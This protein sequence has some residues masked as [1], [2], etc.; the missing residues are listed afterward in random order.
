MRVLTVRQPWAHAIIHFGKDVENRVRN[1]AGGYRGLV[2]IH[3]AKAVDDDAPKWLWGDFHDS[4]Q[5][6]FGSI[7][8]V[9]DLVDVHVVSLTHYDGM[10]VCFDDKTPVGGTC[11]SW[12]HAY[13]EFPAY[14]G[15]HL[16]LSNP[17]PLVEP[18]PFKGALGLRRLDNDMIDRILA[19]VERG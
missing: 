14:H 3:A 12:A 7:I 15:H 8:G 2:A 19:V 16:V 5:E 6:V 11:S 4:E 13:D 18:I 1:V 10:N 9:V 17:R